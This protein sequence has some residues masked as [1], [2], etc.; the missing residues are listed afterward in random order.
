MNTS[1]TSWTDPEQEHYALLFAVR[2]SVRYHRR[3]EQFLDAV[4]RGRMFIT[5]GAGSAAIATW[6]TELHGTIGTTA[7]AV[8]AAGAALELV[9]GLGKGARLHNQLAA[10]FTALEKK[11]IKEG[12]DLSEEN[13]RECVI[14]R[15]NIEADEPPTLGVLNVM[16]HNEMLRA[17][18]RHDERINVTWYQRMAAQMWNIRDDRL[19]AQ[20]PAGGEGGSKGEPAGAKG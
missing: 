12:D 3:R 7:M 16:C 19:I 17:T 10:R 20:T 8:A 1:D 18:G 11:L 9:Y 2:K 4:N 5:A 15:L 6:L 13:R 14:E